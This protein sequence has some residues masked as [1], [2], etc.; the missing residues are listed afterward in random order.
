MRIVQVSS[1]LHKEFG[2]PPVAVFG[3]AAGLRNIGHQVELL[4]F[5][6]NTVSQRENGDFI[7]KLTEVGV[8][9]HFSRSRKTSKY[10][11]IGSVSDLF[12]TVRAIASA[13]I[14]LCH[15]LYNFQNAFV[16]PLARLFN[17]PVVL[18]PHGTLTTYQASKIGIKK[19]IF[20]PYFK[21][22]IDNLTTGIFVATSKEFI[23]LSPR[24][25]L[26]AKVV[27]LGLDEIGRVSPQKPGKDSF[28]FLYLGRITSK[29]R[30]DI[31]LESFAKMKKLTT[32]KTHFNICGS[33]DEQIMADIEKKVSDL[34]L[35]E[36][37]SFLGW[38]A[39]KE[40]I[41][42][43]RISDCF[44]LTSEDENFAI[45]VAES[46][47]NGVPTVISRQVALSQVVE[48]FGAGLVF[49]N[50]DA[51]EIAKVMH[52]IMEMD[53]ELL[54]VSALRASEQFSWEKISV[55][56]SDSL[57]EILKKRA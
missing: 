56:W 45:A 3:A 39:G 10:G 29:K 14:V 32:R 13:E 17:K 50:L 41:E 9:V 22:L 55:F 33:G 21:Y 53:Q 8:G 18:M 11:G 34:N 43:L 28:N 1:A 19:R 54:R 26:K 44:I 52:E 36:Y 16:I 46:L 2:G 48:E 51:S 31:A 40:K 4:V 57:Q 25:K 38:K 5:G 30:I 12:I 35:N 47:Q 37:V 20:S 7:E 42:I 49:E 6:Q 23:E 15:Q 27:G 24:L